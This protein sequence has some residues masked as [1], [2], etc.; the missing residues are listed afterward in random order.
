MVA[1]PPKRI[2]ST[3]SEQVKLSKSKM[4]FNS[5]WLN[6]FP[7]VR[8]D[9][10]TDGAYCSIC[11]KW[12][13]PPPQARGTWVQQSFKAWKKAKEKMCEHAKSNRHKEACLVASEHERSQRQG[14]VVAMVQSVSQKERAENRNVIK[15]LLRCTYFL[16]KNRIAH[17]TNFS[18]L[19]QLVISFG[20]S[21]LQRFLHDEVRN[22]AKYTSTTAVTDF[23]HAIAQWIER[24]LLQSLKQSPYYTLMGDECSD[25]SSME[26][27]FLCFRWL[28]DGKPVEHFL[29]VIHVTRTD[30]ETITSAI[31]SY[32]QEKQIDIGLM[33]GMGFDGAATFSGRRTGVQ[34]RLR[35]LS[36]FA[37]FIHCRNHILQLACVQAANQ[38]SLVKRVYSNL[39]TVWK[40]F[41]YS[42]KKAENLK[43]IQSVL[44]M[45]QLKMLKPTD[46]RWLSHENTITSV[47]RSYT[48]VVVTLETI[49][50]ESGDA[51][52]HGLALLLKKLDTVAAIYML[53]EV[54]GNIARLCKSLQTKGFDLVK[55]PLAVSSTLEELHAI[56]LQW[57]TLMKL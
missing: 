57:K 18:D 23:I 34:A 41:Y 26:E 8:H 6:D 45:P 16:A 35:T 11:E 20:A 54:L 4:S 36:P 25:V 44:N 9:P 13:K 3:R 22:N 12:G 40:L 32:L 28:E 14:T 10:T 29:E 2:K 43:E 51:E 15:K 55:V 48:A 31:T 5:R 49:H 17:T 30:A 50:E 37:I 27:L 21:D 19:V 1:S 46:T 7:W 53:S 56:Q 33:R 38:V 47:K 24:G 52:A 39:T 42:P